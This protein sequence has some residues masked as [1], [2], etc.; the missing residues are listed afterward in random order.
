[1]QW[2]NPQDAGLP[3]P[4][5]SQSR[6]SINTKGLAQNPSNSKP[7]TITFAATTCWAW[8]SSLCTTRM[9]CHRR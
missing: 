4:L 6:A 1:M 7:H 5:S 2:P 9:T 3:T 8:S